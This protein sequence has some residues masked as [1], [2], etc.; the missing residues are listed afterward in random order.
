LA[1]SELEIVVSAKDE[2][3]GVLGGVGDNVERIQNTL[4]AA[5]LREVGQASARVFGEVTG[6]MGDF[7]NEAGKADLVNAQLNAQL[8][9]MGS[10]AAV[11]ADEINNLA[12]EI[13]K[14]TMFEDEMVVSAES[15]LLRFT[16]IGKEIFPEA[17]RA[18]ADLA[19]TMGTDMSSAARLLGRALEDPTSGL[20]TLRRAGIVFTQAE[21]NQIKAMQKAGNIAG[22]QAIVLKALET[23]IGGA[24]E[25]AGQTFPGQVK[26]MENEI[27][28]FKEGVGKWFID[29]F[30]SLPK[31]IRDIGIAIGIVAPQLAGLGGGIV[32]LAAAIL[33]FKAAGG[34]AALTSAASAATPALTG[35]AGAEGAAAAG[36]FAL[37]LPL[38]LLALAIGA[39]IA[40]VIINFDT[41]KAEFEMLYTFIKGVIDRINFEIDKF[42]D[43]LGPLGKIVVKGVGTG[44]ATSFA[45]PIVPL[46]QGVSQLNKA[47]NPAPETGGITGAIPAASPASA[48][49]YFAP[50]SIVYSPGMSMGNKAEFESAFIPLLMSALRK[51]NRGAI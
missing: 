34:I 45:G 47:V 12:K 15:V 14:T 16:S 10:S 27:Q 30:M 4:A 1:K 2:T 36:A 9:A 11:S 37:T 40:V 31:P 28:N 25:A 41:L 18:S 24:A 32:Q 8:K 39:L 51:V 48:G 33:Q 20:G 50:G 42:L 17:T 46:A 43:K 49:A 5:A 21:E 22:A 3:G 26:I 38:A 44:I 23:R 13:S 6:I 29:F 7:V 35:M 19:Q